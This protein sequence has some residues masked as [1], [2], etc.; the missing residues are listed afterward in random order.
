MPFTLIMDILT[1]NMFPVMDEFDNIQVSKMYSLDVCNK[2]FSQIDCYQIMTENLYGVFEVAKT[3]TNF[4]F[5][6]TS[7][8]KSEQK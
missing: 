2:P 6:I 7:E 5:P 4:I 1:E 3:K 8:I